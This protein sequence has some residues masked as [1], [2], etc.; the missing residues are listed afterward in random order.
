MKTT[1]IIS[2]I[3]VGILTGCNNEESIPTKP[4][5]NQTNGN[6]VLSGR[7]S[8]FSYF[9]KSTNLTWDTR[10]AGIHVQIIGTQLSAETDGYGEFVLRGV[11]S[12]SYSL[13]FSKAGYETF[14]LDN[15][16]SNG[17]DSIAIKNMITDSSGIKQTY[18]EVFLSELTPTF[19]I[20]NSTAIATET[21]HA[22]T[23]RDQG[24]IR[25]IRRDTSYSWQAAFSINLQSNTQETQDSLPAGFLI[26]IT[27]SN[28]VSSNEM[29]AAFYAT[30]LELTNG[31][32]GFY[33]HTHQTKP[34]YTGTRD[35]VLKQSGS[36]ADRAISLDYFGKSANYRVQK[37]EQLY[38]HIIPV[39]KELRRVQHSNRFNTWY[40]FEVAYKFGNVE[41]LPIQWQ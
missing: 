20:T 12:G 34:I 17:V 8:L 6:G 31:W 41:T 13:Q 32:L 18:D 37:T 35:F 33:G 24:V 36:D 5:N 14:Q 22:D 2:I 29:P 10:Q 38:L 25:E 19:S 27:N 39:V 7:V 15:I 26:R 4:N 9:L 3:V 40:T 23:V 28:T 30:G 1:L 21:I 11:D 16:Q